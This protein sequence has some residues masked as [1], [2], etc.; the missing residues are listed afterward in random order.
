[1]Q[2]VNLLLCALSQNLNKN[3]FDTERIYTVFKK[4]T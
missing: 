2:I 1:M 3:N 4:Y